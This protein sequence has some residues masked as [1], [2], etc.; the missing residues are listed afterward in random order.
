M[1]KHKLRKYGA[2]NTTLETKTRIDTIYYKL[3][4]SKKFKSFDEFIN[5]LLDNFEEKNK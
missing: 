2:I 1:E 5:L 4:V 3:K